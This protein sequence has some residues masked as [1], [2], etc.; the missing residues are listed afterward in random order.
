MLRT[1]LLNKKFWKIVNQQNQNLTRKFSK[2]FNKQKIFDKL[3]KEIIE[4]KKKN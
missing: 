4:N 3:K 1:F 2:I